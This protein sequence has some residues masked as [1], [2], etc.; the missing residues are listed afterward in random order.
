MTKPT[1]K[2]YQGDEPYIFVSY[3]H[4]NSQIVYRAIEQLCAAYFRVWYD[5]GI[6]PGRIWKSVLQKRVR[7]SRCVLAFLSHDS[8]AS[9]HVIGELTMARNYGKQTFPVYLESTVLP[10]SISEFISSY[11]AIGL[12][13]AE[14]SGR[15]TGLAEALPVET[16]QFLNS[17]QKLRFIE[18]GLGDPQVHKLLQERARNDLGWCSVQRRGSP[19][20]DFLQTCKL[21]GD[22]DWFEAKGLGSPGPAKQ[23]AEC[24]LAQDPGRAKPWFEIVEREGENVRVKCTDCGHLTLYAFDDGPPLVCPKCGRLQYE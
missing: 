5:E 10:A 6:E 9:D 19:Y 18:K 16:R 12:E 1:V 8:V 20:D 3:S 15:W 14:S 4:R 24:G 23:C 13:Q 17:E 11:Q 21:C 7:D 22:T 2:A